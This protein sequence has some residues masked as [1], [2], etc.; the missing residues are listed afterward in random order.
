MRCVYYFGRSCAAH[1]VEMGTGPRTA[2][3]PPEDPSNLDRSGTF[4]YPPHRS[5]IHHE[6][7]VAEMLKSGGINS[8]VESA[9]DHVFGYALS[10]D[11][12]PRDLKGA[13]K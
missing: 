6:T 8:P 12:T 2:F 1:A 11:M 4:P 3:I 13:Q 9:L 10:L 5:D 7:E